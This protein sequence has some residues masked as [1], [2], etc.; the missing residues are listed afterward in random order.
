LQVGRTGV[1]TPVADLDEVQLSGTSVSRAT[2]HN[3]DDIAKK[4]IRVGDYVTVEKAGEIIPAVVSVEIGRRH[5]TSRPFVFPETCPACGSKLI[6]LEGEVAWRC[7][8]SCCLPQICRRLEHFVSRSA[9][10]I[11]GLGVLIVE[12]L[13]AAGK[14][15]NISDIYRLTFDDLKALEKVG[16]KLA[17]K[18]L[19]N[20]DRSKEQPLW[21]LLHGLGISGIGEQ[22]AKTLANNFHSID[23]L[24]AAEPQQLETLNGIGTKLATAV[25]AFF[26]EPNNARVIADLKTMGVPCADKF[27]ENTDQKNP[28]FCGKIFAITGTLGSMPRS[29]IMEKIEKIGGSVANSLSKKTNVLIAGENGG[30]KL[31]KATELGIEIWDEDTFLKNAATDF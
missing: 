12:K 21:R 28:K 14:L 3:A 25:V 31:E 22:M 23:N 27:C 20:V 7:Q 6:R 19:T 30:A 10:D 4:D 1:I 17:L 5:G 24:I 8:N 13:I 9:M 15:Q 26:A 29:E 18:I 2:L 16:T 11:D